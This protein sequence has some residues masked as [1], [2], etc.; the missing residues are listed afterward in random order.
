MQVTFTAVRLTGAI[1]SAI[2]GMV[3]SDI[4]DMMGVSDVFDV[5]AINAVIGE[6]AVVTC[7]WRDWRNC[8]HCLYTHSTWII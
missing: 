4:P 2:Y 6:S 8:V 3:V 1:K 7:H 5:S